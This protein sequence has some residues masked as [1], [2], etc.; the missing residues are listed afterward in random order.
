LKC[1]D[2]AKFIR[3]SAAKGEVL[4]KLGKAD[5][6]AIRAKH[7]L[8]DADTI[9]AGR[10][11]IRGLEKEAFEGLSPAMRKEAGLPDLDV[12][13]PNREIKGPFKNPA[14]TRHAEEDLL[15]RVDEGISK[16]R[17]SANDLNGKTLRIH[18]SNPDGVCNK[19]T[20]G[21]DKPY[22]NAGVLKKF[23]ER[24]PTL[25]I[26]VTAEGGQAVR[27]RDVLVIRNGNILS[28]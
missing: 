4:P 28:K 2:A 8:S 11:D 5:L 22:P 17:L 20:V 21:L 9:A 25:T 12:S 23:S 26:E 1:K 14:F 24:Y 19:C 3:G 7:T 13:A 6:D 18:I 16:L 10:T 27:G 15:N